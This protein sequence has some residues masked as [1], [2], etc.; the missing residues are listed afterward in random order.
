[1]RELAD[2]TATVSGA[3][4]E[5]NC[6]SLFG[7]ASRRNR[8]VAQVAFIYCV[9]VGQSM[10]SL[11]RYSISISIVRLTCA[12]RDP[13]VLRI[14]LGQVIGESLLVHRSSGMGNT[15]KDHFAK[16][17]IVRA[18]KTSVDES[19][20]WPS[21]FCNLADVRMAFQQVGLC[22]CDAAYAE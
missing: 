17:V 10:R 15:R 21:S 7:G 14:Q 6:P 3:S 1:M 18:R 2:T 5:R 16:V 20:R 8:E 12:S 11:F 4:G 19:L 22:K 9:K 13:V